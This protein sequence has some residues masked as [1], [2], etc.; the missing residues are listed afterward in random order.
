MTFK[1]GVVLLVVSSQLPWWLVRSA[2]SGLVGYVPS[3]AL[4]FLVEPEGLFEKNTV[5]AQRLAQ[6]KGARA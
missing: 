6:H 4:T 5:T 2:D 1:A 3:H